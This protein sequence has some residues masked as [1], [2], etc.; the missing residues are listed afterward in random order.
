MEMHL[1]KDDGIYERK[2]LRSIFNL[3]TALGPENVNTNKVFGVTRA[4][5]ISNRC[6]L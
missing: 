5:T 2:E 4:K 1:R 3:L 6:L